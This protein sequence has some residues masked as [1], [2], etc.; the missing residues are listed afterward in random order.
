MADPARVTLYQF[1]RHFGLPNASTFCMKVETWLRMAGIPYDNAWVTN[2]GKMPKGK[3]PAIRHG[4]R[5]LGDSTFILEYLDEHFA[6][7]LDDALDTEQRAIAH[8]FTRMLEERSYW[9]MVYSRWVDDSGWPTTREAFFGAM[10]PGVRDAVATIARRKMRR[11]L[12][13]HGIGLHAR[14]E[15]YALGAADLRAVS[16]WL[17]EKD[18]FMGDAPSAVD[19][20]VYAFVANAL[21][22]LENP[23]ADAAR[24]C[25]NLAPYAERMRDR[26]FPELGD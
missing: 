20:A 9:V 3:C 16:D 11:A 18:F 22:S 17:G 6:P 14:D 25:S 26:Y 2:P 21:H 23:L 10:P 4:G 5:T 19:A 13:A 24:F 15:I 7:G 8:A 1:P 12:R